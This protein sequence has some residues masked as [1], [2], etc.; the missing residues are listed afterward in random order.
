M[1]NG[2]QVFIGI[3]LVVDL[4]VSYWLSHSLISL[5]HYEN[6]YVLTR[7]KR[8]GYDV[9]DADYWYHVSEVGILEEAC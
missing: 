5:L 4:L 1:G 9:F 8:T 6:I 3:D 2:I 7:I